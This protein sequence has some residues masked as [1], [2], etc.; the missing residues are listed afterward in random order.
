MSQSSMGEY[1]V[2]EGDRGL[3]YMLPPVNNYAFSI[4]VK[5]SIKLEEFQ[6]AQI[7]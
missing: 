6:A 4:N 1:R 3:D 7:K 5:L 2:N